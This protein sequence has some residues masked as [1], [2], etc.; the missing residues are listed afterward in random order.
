MHGQLEANANLLV[1]IGAPIPHLAI[2]NSNLTLVI[3][4]EADQNLLRRALSC[5]V[6][7]QKAEDFSSLDRK[8]QIVDR[9]FVSARICEHK[10]IHPNHDFDPTSTRIQLRIRIHYRA[11]DQ[12]KPSRPFIIRRASF[13]PTA[14]TYRPQSP[15]I[16]KYFIL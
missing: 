10:L 5:T 3:A 16:K 11:H 2:E 6:R 14:V 13:A 4:E 8:G 15:C 9:R 12:V 7:S 1:Q